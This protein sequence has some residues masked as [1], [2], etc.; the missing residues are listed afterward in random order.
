M[1]SNNWKSV[2][3]GIE[4]TIISSFFT[5]LELSDNPASKSHTISVS[6]LQMNFQSCSQRQFLLHVM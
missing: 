6:Y 1:K 2:S 5:T 4:T 3:T